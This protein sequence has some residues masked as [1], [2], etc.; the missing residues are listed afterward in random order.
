MAHETSELWKSLFALRNTK[1]EYK[2]DIDGVEY[3]GASEISHSVNGGVYNDFSIGN[4]MSSTLRLRLFADNIP[5]GAVIKRYVRLVNGDAVSEWLLKG[6]YYCNTRA[7]DDD[8]WD[9]TAF[10]A[11]KKADVPYFTGNNIAQWPR[12]ASD[13]VAEIAERMGIA[14]DARTVL[15]AN[16]TVPYPKELTMREVLSNIAVAHI[17]NWIISDTGE[18]WLIP[19]LSAP[20]ETNYLVT[21]IGNAITI[22]GVRILVK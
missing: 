14:I 16:I 21:E 6:V 5:R 22:G 19:L 17:G 10:D 20:E 18:L 11:M 15:D 3:D 7:S 13:V 1:R 4:T 8:I 12:A 2:F 9:I